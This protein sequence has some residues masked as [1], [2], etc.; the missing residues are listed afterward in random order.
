M[1]LVAIKNIK[2]I[3][4]LPIEA[5]RIDWGGFVAVRVIVE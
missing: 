1:Q 5:H 4:Q 2:E 3:Y